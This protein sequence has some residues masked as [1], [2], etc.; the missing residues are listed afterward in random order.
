MNNYLNP[1]KYWNK[2]KLT[3]NITCH[4]YNLEKI[5]IIEREKFEKA[6]LQYDEALQKLENICSNPDGPDFSGEKCIESIHSTLFCAI[7]N[8][9][10]INNILEIGTYM[11]ESTRLLSTIFPD[12]RITTVDLPDERSNAR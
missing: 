11:G 9:S 5:R 8:V 4:G 6:G 10:S 1:K 12:S 2:L 7:S 3:W